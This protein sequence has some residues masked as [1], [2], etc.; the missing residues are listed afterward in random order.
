M[1]HGSILPFRWTVLGAGAFAIFLLMTAGSPA[2]VSAGNGGIVVLPAGGVK[3]R[4]GLRLEL[5]SRWVSGSGYR[6]VR[7]RVLPQPVGPAPADRTIQVTLRPRGWSGGKAGAVVG[8]LELKQGTTF[9]ESVFSVP[10]TNSW[11]VIEIETRESGWRHRELCIENAGFATRFVQYMPDNSPSITI[12][13]WAVEDRTNALTYGATEPAQ[14][15]S[16]KTKSLQVEPAWVLCP[17][18]FGFVPLWLVL[19][20]ARHPFTF[21]ERSG[22]IGGTPNTGSMAFPVQLQHLPDIRILAGRFSDAYQASYGGT[23]GSEV[24]STQTAKT[25]AAISTL[26]N[27]LPNLDLLP[28]QQLPDRWLDYTSIDVLMVSWGELIAIQKRFPQKWA[29]LQTWLRMGPTLVIYDTG[30]DF[31][32]LAELEEILGAEPIVPKNAAEKRWQGWEIPNPAHFKDELNVFRSGASPWTI[33][34]QKSTESSGKAK[35]RPVSSPSDP[36][37]FVSRSFGAG[38][39]VAM[40][41]ADP[42]PGSASDWNGLF[43]SIPARHWLTYQRHGVSQCHEN[44][45]F[46]N[47][48]VEGIGRA[49]VK[50]FLALITLFAIVIGPVNYFLL[51]RCGRLYWLLVTVPLGSL[52]V[53]TGLFMFAIAKDGLGTKVRLRSYTE[54]NQVQQQSMTWSR[55]TYYAGFATSRGLSFPEDSAVF[56]IEHRPISRMG[57]EDTSRLLAWNGRQQLSVGY[58]LSRTMTQFI[59]VEPKLARSAARIV[60]R[61]TGSP[62]EVTNALGA[63]IERL[64]LRDSLGE[65]YQVIGL[66]DGQKSAGVKVADHAKVGAEWRT[67]HRAARP[68]FP[69]GFDANAMD[70][71]SQFFAVNRWQPPRNAPAPLFETSVLEVGL[72]EA[73]DNDFEQLAPRMFV[74]ILSRS[75]FVSLGVDSVSHET[76]FHVVVGRW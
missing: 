75:P 47:F 10:Q 17:E 14:I 16:N 18:G 12:V 74:A 64:V 54:L 35:T 34:Q 55:Q 1:V 39:V 8:T 59:V 33:Q 4:S 56:P 66:A 7:V 46:W 67:I 19:D 3:N 37:W 70:D 25:D 29:A 65:L 63:P 57:S 62:P 24:F 9:G 44:P 27:D 45:Q 48:L 36:P 21:F 43:N 23:N 42:F 71:V 31:A 30:R 5:D 76:G 15:P 58:F 13:H 50:T 11:H 40:A 53:A 72:R 26:V 61:S 49:P 68:E 32:R 73:L 28:P 20:G 6:P 51:H 69:P 52:I 38:R 2:R 60:E 22:G 41:T